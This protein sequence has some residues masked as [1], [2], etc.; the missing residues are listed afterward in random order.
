MLILW[1]SAVA[2]VGGWTHYNLEA[3]H[4]LE[5]PVAV[6]PYPVLSTYLAMFL[7]GAMFLALGLLIS[8][9]VRVQ[10]VAALVA[11]ALSLPFIK[12]EWLLPGDP[13]GGWSGVVSFLSVP[14]HFDRAF[15]RGVIDTRPLVLYASVALFC[16]F[17]TTR[18]V[19]S[20]QWR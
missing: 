19:E 18:S 3:R 12:P 10:L 5:I 20:R 15:T 7:V 6:D 13:G 17:L 9:L 14:F 11:L 2:L 1:G 16:L 4:L 8:S